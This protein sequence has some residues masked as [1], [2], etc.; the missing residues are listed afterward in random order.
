M[1]LLDT[2]V[3]SELRRGKRD[4]SDAVRAWA[5]TRAMTQLYLSAITVLELEIGVRRMQRKDEA[6]GAMLRAWADTVLREF[7]GRLLP[8]SA[9]TAPRCADLHAPDPRSF[10]DSMIAATALE[11]GFAVVT[12]NTGDFEGTG[13][14]LINPW[15]RP[16]P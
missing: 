9:T 16:A 15:D 3:I 2:N 13:V 8:F 10:R 5:S 4:Q 7:D 1:Y 12:R 14:T 11:H 6:Q